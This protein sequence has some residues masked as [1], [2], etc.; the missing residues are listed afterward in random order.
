MAQRQLTEFV[1]PFPASS[2]LAHDFFMLH[3]TQP[4]AQL[5]HIDAAHEYRDVLGRTYACGGGCWTT[6]DEGGIMLGDDFNTPWPGVIRAA[7]EHAEAYGLKLET[8][9]VKW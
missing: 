2:R 7:C 9:D 1:I 4:R 3:P 6:T 8:W 5:I